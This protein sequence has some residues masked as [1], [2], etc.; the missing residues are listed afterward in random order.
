ML[1]N[2]LQNALRHTGAGGTVRLS[3]LV[4][5]VAAARYVF[6]SSFSA[7]NANAARALSDTAGQSL[8]AAALSDFDPP[9]DTFAW[10]GANNARPDGETEWRSDA[11]LAAEL[12]L[13]P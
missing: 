6:A 7:S 12:P 3:V 4:E 9:L 2:L 8:V 5:A 11:V 13:R 1:L 10:H